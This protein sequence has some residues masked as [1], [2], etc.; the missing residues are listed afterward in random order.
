MS[1]IHLNAMD[2]GS[3]Q[4]TLDLAKIKKTREDSEQRYGIELSDLVKKV[5]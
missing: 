1:A 5:A 4:L 3:F 2:E